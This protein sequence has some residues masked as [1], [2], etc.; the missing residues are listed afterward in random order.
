[1]RSNKTHG[2]MTKDM[3][4]FL[5][6]DMVER[7]N[8]EIDNPTS[9]QLAFANMQRSITN[10]PL[11]KF[12]GLSTYGHRQVNHDPISAALVGYMNGGTQG[13]MAAYAHMI[14]DTFSDMLVRQYGAAGRD[15]WESMYMYLTDKPK[16]RR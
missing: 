3:F 12:P 6:D 2:R 13:A 4:P 11:L 16:R 9:W 10:E 5:N 8:H 14:Q 7:V 1:M 15:L